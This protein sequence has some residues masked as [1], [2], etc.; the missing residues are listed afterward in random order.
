LPD[1]DIFQTNCIGLGCG[2][3]DSGLFPVIARINH[4]CIPNC[5][6]N[7]NPE[8]QTEFVFATKTIR[9]GEEIQSN[10]LSQR[11][12]LRPRKDRQEELQQRYHFFCQ[13]EGCNLDP[14][15]AFRSDERR[16]LIKLRDDSIPRLLMQNEH[17][18]ALQHVKELLHLLF[19]EKL[20]GILQ[21]RACYDAF[22]VCVTV[23]NLTEA[24]RWIDRAYQYWKTY[25][26]PASIQ[27]RLGLKY[28]MNP[29]S[30]PHWGLLG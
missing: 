29:Q 22:Q 9:Q 7:W 4:S 5:H 6:W 20:E 13:C 21:A 25:E 24:Q 14:S 2:S 16:Q 12:L 30:H 10:Y 26:G 23:R 17:H 28:S 3:K 1:I 11:S 19:E 15:Y 8:L 18:I 27:T